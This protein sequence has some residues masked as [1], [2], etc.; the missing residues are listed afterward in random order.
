MPVVGGGGI[1]FQVQ[2]HTAGGGPN[3][4]YHHLPQFDVASG[5]YLSNEMIMVEAGRNQTTYTG[6][7]KVVNGIDMSATYGP[8]LPWDG[9]L[10]H[11]VGSA[12]QTA[13]QFQGNLIIYK[14]GVQ[15]DS[16]G[17]FWDWQA[18]GPS[19]WAVGVSGAGI[20]YSAGDFF[21]LKV[22]GISLPPPFA[23]DNPL[24]RSFFFREYV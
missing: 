17:G 18:G 20:Q 8:I 19:Y 5:L 4:R 6:W 13:P 24:V 15:V 21:S 3:V 10:M 14:N 16:L 2:N 9:R 23:P 1:P 11:V 7:L 12:Y 22:T